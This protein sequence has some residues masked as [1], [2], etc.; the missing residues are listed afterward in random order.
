MPWSPSL[1]ASE[2]LQPM[3]LRGR[4]RPANRNQPSWQRGRPGSM[5]AKNR[6]AGGHRE[7]SS[8]TGLLG[9]PARPGYLDFQPDRVTWTSSQTGLLGLPARPGYLDFQPDRVTWASSQTGLLGLPARP[10]YLDL[11]TSFRKSAF[12]LKF[13]SRSSR[14][15]SDATVFDEPSSPTASRTRRI[16]VV[17]PRLFESINN[18][19]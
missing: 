2:R 10:G 17:A 7:G 13:L 3:Q 18:S 4:A 12:V 6:P 16:F 15:S 9:L 5:V 14:R 8:Q 19:S 11:A 1:L